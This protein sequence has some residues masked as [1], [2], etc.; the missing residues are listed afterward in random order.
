MNSALLNQSTLENDAFVTGGGADFGEMDFAWLKAAIYRSRWILL[1]GAILGAVIGLVLALLATP[2]YT[3]TATI[4]IESQGPQILGGESD[5]SGIQETNEKEYRKTQVAILTSRTLLERVARTLNYT[6]DP[7]FFDRLDMDRPSSAVGSD[8]YVR[9]VVS[10]LSERT[11][12]SEQTDTR[13]VDIHFTGPDPKQAQ[14][15]VN[16]IGT[17]FIQE[18]LERRFATTD[19]S[20]RYLQQ[21]IDRTRALLQNSERALINYEQSAGITNVGPSNDDK[22]HVSLTDS[23]LNAMNDA[24]AKA[25]S[26]RILAE[27][28]WSK[29]AGAALMS[30]PEVMNNPTIQSMQIDRAGK[31]TQLQ[32]EL[33]RH[34]ETYPTVQTLR[35]QIA[36]IDVMMD[37]AAKRIRQS[38]KDQYDIARDQ[39]A[40]MAQ[41]VT[42][43]RN[44][45]L[46]EQT[47]GIQLSTLKR[48]ADTNHQLY[49]ALLGRFREINATAGVTIN[50]ISVIDPAE[51]PQT[52]VWPLPVFN[53]LIGLV[54]GAI[55]GM[56]V[57]FLRERLDDTVRTPDEVE[58]RLG[59]P[60]VGLVPMLKD[61]DVAADIADPTSSFSE[62]IYSIRTSLQLATAHGIPR[63]LAFTST[64]Q[65]EGKSTTALA[66]AKELAQSGQRTLII[67]ADLR[68][69]AL[70]RH[71][72]LENESG[73]S[74]LLTGQTD[75][76]SLVRKS[77][78][79]GDL[80]IMT[81]GPLPVSAPRL[82]TL[83][84]IS[85]AL[86]LLTPSYDVIIIDCPPVL[87]LADALQISSATEG[88]LYVHEAGRASQRQT[89]SSLRRLRRGGANVIG[90]LL[91]KF[92]FH[93]DGYSN[94]G[95]TQYYYNY[96]AAKN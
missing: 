44:A 72:G 59:L 85:A 73:F 65:G 55:A 74:N 96:E 17:Q 71:C 48:D 92:D 28:Q 87:G 9:S 95:Y 7:A 46:N 79:L 68:R 18:T 36:S 42:A 27:T 1:G 57:A 61:S 88:T 43:L 77:A 89:I 69:P 23:N 13:L 4:Q 58:R 86:D 52:P 38:I 31:V 70:H 6:K 78:A 91:T 62:S 33:E 29:T 53:F 56:L 83:E 26:A 16:T 66:L 60:L 63:T 32:G 21:Q 82:L 37:T 22:S 15:I 5:A 67:D 12:V 93:R 2:L 3:A 19:Y 64:Q 40:S 41:S 50:N 94:Y 84:T 54:A 81:S 35:A 20:R 10:A 8:D 30:I 90:I 45:S 14:S 80:G 39:E 75:V 24:F 51:V 47:R 76:A 49:D 11:N 25:Q 34:S